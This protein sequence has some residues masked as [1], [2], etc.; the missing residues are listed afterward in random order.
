[1]KKFF[2][3]LLKILLGVLITIVIFTVFDI[4]KTE[5][6]A[7]KIPH[8]F[9]SVEEGQTLV[10]ANTDYYSGYTQNDID[11]RMKKGGAT[12]DELLDVTKT[13]VKKFNILEK[14]YIDHRIAKMYKTLKKNHYTLPE[15]DEISF[16]KIDMD[17]EGGANGY[18]HGTEIYLN[19]T[20]VTFNSFL[21]F[22]PGFNESMD[23]LL[24]HE[25]FHCLTRCNPEF[26]SQMYSLINFTVVDSDYELPPCIQEKYLSNP[27]VEHHNSYATFQ[28]DGREIDCFVV[29][30]TTKDYAND[31]A[32]WSD[33]EAVALVP[34]DG[35]DEYFLSEQATNFDEVF[36]T[37]TSYVIDPE[38]CMA[39]NFAYAML[40]GMKG[41]GGQ[42][43]PNPEIVQ[44]IIDSVSR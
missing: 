23:K 41:K 12:L 5:I 37:N 26:R 22:I 17:L 42:G 33:S 16:V 25:M 40:Y 38:E 8:R 18:T 3:V 11:M 44:G 43:Y 36:G 20:L 6:N 32:G 24:W 29:W 21:G 9:A 28:I 30:I 1:M 14:L 31:G 27:D 4:C 39:D 13:S 10:L 15:T 35:S 19:A 2:L 7:K 34:I